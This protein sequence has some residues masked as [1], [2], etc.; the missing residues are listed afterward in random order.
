MNYLGVTVRADKNI[1]N[2][3]ISN[4]ENLFP[5]KDGVTAYVYNTVK[6]RHRLHISDS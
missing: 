5:E 1:N 2:K 3:L 6:N 4:V